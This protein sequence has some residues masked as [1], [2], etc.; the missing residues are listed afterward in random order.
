MSITDGSSEL[1]IER[2]AHDDGGIYSCMFV[3]NRGNSI[4]NVTTL[5]VL[6]KVH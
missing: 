1:R 5:L 6:G 2:V 4:R 3:N